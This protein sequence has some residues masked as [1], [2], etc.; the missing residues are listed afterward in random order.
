MSFRP[1]VCVIRRGWRDGP[2]SYKHQASEVYLRRDPVLCETLVPMLNSVNKSKAGVTI[3][4]QCL[5][6]LVGRSRDENEPRRQNPV[7]VK[8][9]PSSSAGNSSVPVNEKGE[10]LGR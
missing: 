9:S 2:A 1:P 3:G 8:Q 5:A 4:I 10:F 7:H 6:W